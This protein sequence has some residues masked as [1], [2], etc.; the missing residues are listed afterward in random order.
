MASLIFVARTS[1]APR[2]IKGKPS[3]LF[4]WLGWSLLPVAMMMSFLVLMAK[5]YSIS[6][7]G[8]AIA[9]TIGLGA[10]LSSIFGV[11]ISL[12]ESPTNTSA[13]FIAS[14][15]VSI[16]LYDANSAFSSESSSRS[17]RITPLLSS[18]TIFS[19]LA[20]KAL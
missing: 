15:R 4:T 3:T 11:T 9:K 16:F 14:S 19:L 6:G 12:T 5:S 7:S 17:F 18:I 8:L 10:M 20:P 1:N 13:S 2:K